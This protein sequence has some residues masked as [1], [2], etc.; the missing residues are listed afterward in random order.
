ME[1]AESWEG[2]RVL[3]MHPMPLLLLLLVQVG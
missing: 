3:I 2:A 1:R